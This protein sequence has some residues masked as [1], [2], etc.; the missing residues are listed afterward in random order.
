MLLVSAKRTSNISTVRV[1]PHEKD[2]LRKALKQLG[3]SSIAH[4]FRHAMNTL[5]EQITLGDELIWPLRFEKRNSR[6][7]GRDKIVK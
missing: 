2:K 1:T 4:F 7:K 5:L 3:F 6:T